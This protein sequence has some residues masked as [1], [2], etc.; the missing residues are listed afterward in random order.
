[1]KG[2]NIFFTFL[3]S[4]SILFSSCLF[5]EEEEKEKITSF[6]FETESVTIGKGNSKAVKLLIEPESRIADAKVEYTLSSLENENV[7][8][9]NKSSSGLVLNASNRGNNVV[10]AKCEGLTAF[11]E[12]SVY[13]DILSENPY[14]ELTKQAIEILPNQRES[15]QVNLIGGEENESTLFEWKVTDSEVISIEHANNACII[16]GLKKGF[17]FIE[18]T[19]PKVSYAAKVMVY[20]NQD[21]ENPVY[22]TSSQSVYVFSVKNGSQNIFFNLNNSKVNN[23]SLFEYEITQGENLCE[24]ISN[25]NCLTLTPKKEGHIILKAVHD[26]SMLPCTVHCFIVNEETPLMIESDGSFFEMKRG[27]RVS[28]VLRIESDESVLSMQNDFSVF[29]EDEDICDADLVNS[30]LYI[31][32]K[33]K[34]STKIK[35]TSPYVLNPHEIYVNV[36]ENEEELLWISCDIPVIKME[37]GDE[38]YVLPVTLNGGNEN[39]KNSFKWTVS[40]SSIIEVSTANGN[41]NYLRSAVYNGELKEEDKAYIKALKEG[42]AEITVT[43]PKAEGEYKISVL[44]YPENTL[45]NTMPLIT[46][47]SLIKIINGNSYEVPLNITGG[48]LSDID[49][50]VNDDNVLLSLSNQKVSLYAVKKGVTKLSAKVGEKLLYSASIVTGSSEEIQNYSYLEC[51]ECYSVLK[52]GE[53]RNFRII[54]DNENFDVSVNNP[55][56]IRVTKT[57][58]IINV[59]ALKEGE[60]LININGSAFINDLTIIV[61]VQNELTID[62]PYYF[63]F[64]RFISSVINTEKIISVGFSCEDENEIQKIYWSC[65]DEQILQ[66]NGNGKSCLIKGLKKGQTVLKAQSL[67][68]SNE[69]KIIVNIVENESELDKAVLYSEK[70]NYLCSPGDSIFLS[71]EV[72]DISKIYDLSWNV[73][74]INVTSIDA[75]KNTCIVKC[76]SEGNSVIKYGNDE[77]GYISY[78][79]SVK[80][81]VNDDVK[82]INTVNLIEMETGDVKNLQA[83]I[84]GFSENEIKDIEWTIT[85]GDAIKINPNGSECYIKALK[86]GF[87][88]L[89]ASYNS[90]EIYSF[91]NI[92]VYEKGSVHKPVMI[93]DKNIYEVK[94]YEHFSIDIDYGTVK[95]SESERQSLVFSCEDENSLLVSNQDKCDAVFYREGKYEINV[96][97]PYFMNNLKLTVIVKDIKESVSYSFGL[98]KVLKLLKDNDEIITVQIIDDKNKPVNDPSFTVEEKDNDNTISWTRNGNALIINAVEKGN[99]ILKFH[100][101]YVEN[102]FEMLVYVFESTEEMDNTYIM[103]TDKSNH[104]IRI[105]QNAELKLQTEGISQESYISWSCSDALIC[106]FTKSLNN[107]VL[108]V[109]GKKE[110]SVIFTATNPYS[111]STV[112]FY[113]SVSN[114]ST[115]KME[116]I[117]TPSVIVMEKYRIIQ[118]EDEENNIAEINTH[119]NASV[120]SN[121]DDSILSNLIWSS[122]NENILKLDYNSTS[123]VLEGVNEGLCEINIGFNNSD[124]KT[125]VVKV[126]ENENQISQSCLFNIDKRYYR[127]KKGSEINLSF[128]CKEKLC[129]YSKTTVTDVLQNNV[130]NAK[131][132]NKK[133]NV[134]AVNEGIGQIH[135][136]NTDAE[137]EFDVYFEVYEED[138]GN[139]YEVK[140]GSLFASQTLYSL[141][142][143]NKNNPVVINTVPVNIEE[144][145]WNTILWENLDKDVCYITSENEKCNV[146][147][148]KEGI[149]EIKCS[150]IFSE[151]E[152]IYTVVCSK[153]EDNLLPYLYCENNTVKL[154]TG[155]RKDLSF[156]IKNKDVTD[157]LKFSYEIEDETVCSIQ[158]QGNTVSIKGLKY[159]QTVLKVSYDSLQEINVVISVSGTMENIV[160][161]TSS[162]QYSVIGKDVSKKIGVEL[163]GYEETNQN[164]FKWT[165]KTENDKEYVSFTGSGKDIYVR[166]L[167]E[168]T[169]TLICTHVNSNPLNEALCPLEITLIITEDES[170]VITYIKSPGVIN[171]KKGKTETV[172]FEL[173]NGSVTENECFSYSVPSEYKKYISVTGSQN[174]AVIQGLEVGVSRFKV[175]NQFSFGLNEIDVIVVVTENEEEGNIMITSDSTVIEGKLSDSYKTVNVK[176]TNGKAED[177]QKFTWEI[178]SYDSV[179]R[180]TDGS[181]LPVIQLVSQNG[182]Q[183]IVKYLREGN[184]TVRVRNSVTS[185][186]LDLKFIINEYTSLKFEKASVTMKQFEGE[187]VNIQSPNGK[188]VVYNSSDESIVQVYGTNK[189]CMI[190]ALK[191]GYAVITARTSDGLYEDQLSVRVNENPE[192]VPCY[193][194]S[195]VSIVSLDITDKTG[196]TIKSVL[197]G[198]IG[199]N[200]VNESENQY[201]EYKLKSNSNSV[202]KFSGSNSLSVKG[203]QAVIVPVG[204]GEE[205]IEVRH[206]KASKVKKIYVTVNAG[207]VSL[208]L[209]KQYEVHKINDIGSVTAS[210]V[211]VPAS[212]ESNIVWNISDTSIVAFN[213]SG[214]E[215]SSVK[216]SSVVYRCKKLCENGTVITCTYKDTVK[217]FTVFIKEL[218]QLSILASSDIVRTGQSKWYNIICNPEEYLS[219]LN[220]TYSSSSYISVKDSNVM[221]TGLVRNRNELLE[222]NDNPPDGIRVPYFKVTGGAK[223]GE[224]SFNFECHNM[225][226]VLKVTT[227]NKI[228]FDL[229][230]YDEYDKRGIVVQHK[231]KP[232]VIEVSADSSFT[233]VYYTLNDDLVLDEFKNAVCNGKTLKNA[234]RSGTVDIS[235]GKNTGTGRYFDIK[236]DSYGSNYGDLEIHNNGKTV[237]VIRVSFTMKDADKAFKFVYTDNSP[238]KFS[239]DTVNCI[240]RGAGLGTNM[241]N[242][243]IPVM[244]LNYSSPYYYAYLHNDQY[245]KITGDMNIFDENNL[246]TSAV[247]K[248]YN[249][250][251]LNGSLKDIQR[252]GTVEVKFYW[253]VQYGVTACYSKYY[254]FY[255]EIWK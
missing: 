254:V 16:T 175:S 103:Y 234:F 170:S 72:S 67:K 183:N 139:V 65:D 168:G 130:C 221:M 177:Y 21:K 224:T 191:P 63:T 192:S 184:A 112:I 51:D 235:N 101:D 178:V 233:R 218:P 157:P 152:I 49:F 249:S 1:M 188:T 194:S 155:E 222:S 114:Y 79:I 119:Y 15:F 166:G 94:P 125:V 238:K 209:E 203:S 171:L 13:A 55:E 195:N 46:G 225:S 231:D 39:D 5:N 212:E 147:P 92:A 219:E 156:E 32:A 133:L 69:V 123:A 246:I 146:Y 35:V 245:M 158:S 68:S 48:N 198:T 216:G 207:N 17:S 162:Q 243:I 132:V 22:I 149:C 116:N 74:N 10:I 7:I 223:E 108:T 53:T 70:K 78:F 248:M 100:S 93:S 91:T 179:L 204:S 127:I 169:A 176:L 199:G 77:T 239:Y 118:E 145:K 211:G 143:D 181:S 84:K 61:N 196:Y 88:V 172:N 215:V 9:S 25:N 153:N 182:E 12:C 14:I 96:S 214:G 99:C 161:L 159:G 64:D 227:S 250:T 167:K 57:G 140:K 200:P 165:Y 83:S 208:K 31:K 85:E 28:T 201:I 58:K 33:A 117:I 75:D 3:I 109:K 128:F 107:K 56:I 36:T 121:L 174:M 228:N 45:V 18:I 255:Q 2:K 126:C 73:S 134:K 26:E 42:K 251:N 236:P 163:I 205:E 80:E 8:L 89:K 29:A 240:I 189:V 44:V 50:T 136:S 137:N 24:I 95:P 237:A 90:N 226:A 193:I 197:A 52:E 23:L 98:N 59:K 120:I 105:G 47:P 37:R 252:R 160:Y 60:C 180:N 185:N 202:I 253:P 97:S 164:N 34:G 242:G 154:K 76:L 230:S 247:P 141:D 210:L 217:T 190:D 38:D 43:H 27:E 54:T 86:D 135:L 11:L 102:D 20:V 229:L 106:S 4:V 187:T 82:S 62:K 150:S 144:E 173:V 122:S 81:N 138:E 232:S 129:D 213:T 111:P 142:V 40:D 186:F 6:K 71:C 220:Y 241:N 113:V 115:S 66:I 110:G 19:H 30:V 104:L 151:N 244:K 41:V 131:I 148:L 206:S 124:K 87:S